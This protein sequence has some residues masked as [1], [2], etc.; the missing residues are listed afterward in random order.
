METRGAIM[1]GGPAM[2]LTQAPRSMFAGDELKIWTNPRANPNIV[3]LCRSCLFLSSIV[4]SDLSRAVQMLNGGAA[5]EQVFGNYV[6]VIPLISVQ[7]AE[8]NLR[9]NTFWFSYLT[10]LG[11]ATTEFKLANSYEADELT[12]VLRQ[13]F[14]DAFLVQQMGISLLRICGWPFFAMALTGLLAAALWFMVNTR[15]GVRRREIFIESWLQDTVGPKGVI[16]FAAVVGAILLLWMVGRFIQRPVG[17][18]FHKV[19]E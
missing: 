15:D 11:T 17:V 18:S 2:S 9:T 16:M 6:K 19:T 12:A 4:K 13:Q 14:G 5:P 1:T 8:A 7:N 3:V 10:G